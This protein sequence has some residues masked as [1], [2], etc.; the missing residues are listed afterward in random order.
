MPELP[1]V[2]TIKKGL[3]KYL[4]GHKIEDVEVRR[5]KV[6]SG[7]VKDILGAKILGARRFA[8]VIAI[9]L[10][11]GYTLL[12]H[13]KLTGQF[14][15]RGPNLKNPPVLSDKVGTLPG[16]H[17]HVIFKLDKGGTLYFNDMRVFGWIR[18]VKTKE[19]LDFD[20]IKKLGPEPFNGLT[21]EKFK[22]IVA[23]SKT[24]IKVLLMDQTKIGGVGNIYANDALWL[25]QVDPQRK[26]DS[27]T[28]SEQEKLYE[29]ILTV[30]KKGLELGGASEMAFVSPSGGEGEYQ[31][32]FLVYGQAE[33]TCPRCKKE[34]I[35]RVA[36]GGRGTFFCPNC[37]K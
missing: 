5:A 18:V 20:F 37:Q 9:D 7:E 11:N 1:E 35:K 14:I 12:A 8:K 4:V 16:K 3:N 2:E 34:K 15:Y 6:F 30:L 25:A 21:E 31:K 27:L 24:A 17:T 32:H 10:S 19:V 33:K 26:A 13:V 23:K 28:S 22:E 36:L 29:A